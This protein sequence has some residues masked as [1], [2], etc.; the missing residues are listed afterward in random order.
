MGVPFPRL[1]R[2]LGVAGAA[3]ACEIAATDGTAREGGRTVERPA[4]AGGGGDAGGG[5]REALTKPP[6]TRQSPRRDRPPTWSEAC[7]G[8]GGEIPIPLALSM[9]HPA[10]ASR[11]VGLLLDLDRSTIHAVVDGTACASAPLPL[12]RPLYAYVALDASRTGAVELQA[13]RPRRRVRR[14]RRRRARRRRS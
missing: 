2:R 7:A 14:R 13:P 9:A 6:L 5:R 1:V 8:E 12:P 4:A 3:A 10:G 11:R